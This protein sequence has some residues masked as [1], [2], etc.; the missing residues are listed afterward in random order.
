VWWFQEPALAWL[1]YCVQLSGTILNISPYNCGVRRALQHEPHSC[2]WAR[3]P[4]LDALDL[5]FLPTCARSIVVRGLLC[6]EIV[7]GFLTV[8]EFSWLQEEGLTIDSLAQVSAL[9][10]NLEWS[11]GEYQQ[12]KHTCRV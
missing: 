3:V 4:T 12:F 5:Y 9:V 10:F 7:S 11:G 8:L 2:G 6:M 1:M